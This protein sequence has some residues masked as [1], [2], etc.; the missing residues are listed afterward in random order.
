M[1][2]EPADLAEIQRMIDASVSNYK[3]PPAPRPEYPPSNLIYEGNGQYYN[4]ENGDQ[5]I[6]AG[7]RLVKIHVA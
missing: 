5:W 2:L 7:G 4:P 1:P 6:K 3:P